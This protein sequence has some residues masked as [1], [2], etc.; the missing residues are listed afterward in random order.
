[1]T[2]TVTD[3]VA[4]H[5]LTTPEKLATVDLASGRKHSYAEMNDRVSRIAGFLREA[6]IEPG[7]RVGLI[8]MNSSDVLDIIFATWRIGAVHLALNFRLTAQELAFIVDDASPKLVISDVAFAAMVG[9]LRS[10]TSGVRWVE[11]DGLGGETEFE[12][13]L[14]GSSRIGEIEAL[15][16]EEQAMLMYSSGTTGRP[17]G[18]II[19]HG[20]ML[21]AVLNEAINFEANRNSVSYAVL[22]LFH[23]GAMMGFSVPVLFF[24]GT[25]VIE[26]VFEPGAMLEAI[27]CEEFGVTHFLGLPAVYNALSQ[28]PD[29][30]DADF[31]RII[32]AAGGAEPMPEPLLRWWFDHGVP[33]VEVYGMTETCGLACSLL[34]ED[35]PGRIGSAGKAA[36][37]I[38]MKIMKSETQE[39]AAGE[40]GEI[41]MK[42]AN[43]TPGYWQR[44]EADEQSFVAGWLKSGDIGRKDEDGYIYVDDRIK[45]MY[46]SG[47]ENV[48]PA[49]VE[50]ILYMMPQI[51]EVAVIGVADPKW[52]EVGCAVVVPADNQSLD[53]ETIKRHCD[54]HLAKY[55][56]PQSL[57]IRTELP[58]NA[59][60]KVLKFILRDEL[61]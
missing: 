41:W 38:D 25:A 2:D 9:D 48:Y 11:T 12:N 8:A 34:R 45:D 39:A 58:R 49:E 42:G 47:G 22:P 28:H 57:D 3:W 20:M 29:C 43:V 14:K 59:T 5:A 4:F 30:K 55:K 18:V 17:K 37:F 7:D 6:G 26:R 40:Q 31:S 1:M 46:I 13:A 27:T 51:S 44:P 32:I 35:V 19:T 33:I 15:G 16:M 21:A 50:N 56:H 24:G 61:G 53:L 10:Q 36:M 52:G 54:E 60:G 23:I